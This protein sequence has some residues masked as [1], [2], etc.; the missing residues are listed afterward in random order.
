MTLQELWGAE[1]DHI[2]W[3]R[4]QEQ[5]DENNPDCPWLDDEDEPTEFDKDEYKADMEDGDC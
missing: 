4:W 2:N 5:V 3:D 1:M